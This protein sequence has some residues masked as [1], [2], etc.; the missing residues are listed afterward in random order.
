MRRAGIAATNPA[1]PDLLKLISLGVSDEDFGLV[2]AEAAARSKGFAWALAT[3]LGR[4]SDAQRAASATASSD[5]ETL[6]KAPLGSAEHRAAFA[7]TVKRAAERS[8]SKA[9]K[10]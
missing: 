9:R 2:A 7:R 8:G 10:A 4:H 6:S 5:A 3:L 1:H